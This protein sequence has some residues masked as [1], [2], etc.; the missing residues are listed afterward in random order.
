MN[1]LF[2]CD[3]EGEY[4][5]IRK[6]HPNWVLKVMCFMNQGEIIKFCES[7][8][9]NLYGKQIE[10]YT[11][12][13]V[14]MNEI[15]EMNDIEFKFYRKTFPTSY[16]RLFLE[17]YKSFVTGYFLRNKSKFK[18]Y[19]LPDSKTKNKKQLAPLKSQ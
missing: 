18:A 7:T 8:G 13:V 4:F 1:P 19:K 2:V 12:M 17:L 10:G 6:K 9:A 3:N 5:L 11:V 16:A 14:F 15:S